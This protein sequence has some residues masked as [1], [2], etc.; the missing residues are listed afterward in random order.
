MIFLGLPLTPP[1]IQVLDGRKLGPMMQWAIHTTLCSTLR[2]DA[3]QFPYQAVM[4]PVS[5]PSMVQLSNFL[6]IWRPMPNLF[7]LLRGKRCC[8]A[9][10]LCLEH[11]HLLV[12]WTPR[13]LKLLIRS[14][15]ASLM[16]MQPVCPPFPVVYD[17]LLCLAHIQRLLSWHHTSRSLFFWRSRGIRG[18]CLGWVID[19]GPALA[20]WGS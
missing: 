18:R 9:V 3:E 2:S 8:R 7:S 4:N 15:T 16:L 5:M 6:R 10:L 1:S 13:N 17:Q 12:M 11:E 19:S 14:T 20:F